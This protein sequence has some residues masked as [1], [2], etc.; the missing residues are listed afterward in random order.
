[1]FL[2]CASVL[3]YCE[4]IENYE[5]VVDLQTVKETLYEYFDIPLSVS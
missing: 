3:Y 4:K 5:Q 1:M 2:F